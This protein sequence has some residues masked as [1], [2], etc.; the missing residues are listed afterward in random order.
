MKTFPIQHVHLQILRDMFCARLARH[1]FRSLAGSTQLYRF[2]AMSRKISLD[3]SPPPYPGSPQGAF[4][5]SVFKKSI[6][7]LA[8]RTPPA[9][10]GFVLKAPEMRGYTARHLPIH[11]CLMPGHQGAHGSSKNTERRCRSV[12]S[13]RRPPGAAP[14]IERR[15]GSARSC[16]AA[17]YGLTRRLASQ[18]NLRRKRRLF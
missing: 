2:P 12:E 1:S 6:N 13:G 9:R 10:T 4:D 18:L 15:Y 8:A 11:P 16:G 7:I 3:A 5:R 17:L 14:C